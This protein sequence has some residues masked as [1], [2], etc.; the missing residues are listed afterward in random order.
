MRLA[1]QV[2]RFFHQ[3]S[4]YL[5]CGLWSDPD[6]ARKSMGEMYVFLLK[7]SAEVKRLRR[8][9]CRWLGPAADAW[10]L[11]KDSCLAG[12]AEE[13]CENEN[14]LVRVL[15]KLYLAECS[16]RQLDQECIEFI[17]EAYHSTSKHRELVVV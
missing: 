6:A 8:S 7:R 3:I 10:N 14:Y 4:P 16:E 11:F 17:F 12:V 2:D 1:R 13:L 5:D 9:S 15:A